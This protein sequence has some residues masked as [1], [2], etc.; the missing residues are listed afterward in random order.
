VIGAGIHA[1]GVPAG[2]WKQGRVDRQYRHA[3]DLLHGELTQVTRL[4]IYP[5]KGMR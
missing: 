4:A 5:V 3:Q 1:I 2:W